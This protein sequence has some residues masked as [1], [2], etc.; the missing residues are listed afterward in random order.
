MTDTVS[1][2]NSEFADRGQGKGSTVTISCRICQATYAPS[3]E[4]HYLLQAPPM[5]LESAFMSMCHFCFRCR[6]PACPQCW[7]NVH[8]VCGECC[9]EAQLPFRAQTAPL[10]GVLFATTRQAQLHRKHA[11]PVRLICIRPGRF[12][13]M[14]S[15]DTAETM[16][17]Q[18]AIARNVLPPSTIQQQFEPQS[19]TGSHANQDIEHIPTRPPQSRQAM[20]TNTH[21]ADQPARQYRTAQ[22]PERS[23]TSRSIDE[24]ATRPPRSRRTVALNDSIQQPDREPTRHPDKS[25]GKR[26]EQII[27]GF[28][29]TLLFILLLTVVIALLSTEVNSHVQQLLH[30]DIRAEI[31]YLWQLI[32]QIHT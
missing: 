24:I 13:R 15:I 18:T 5:A 21:L 2:H 4:H 17:I 11:L 10:R 7:D 9:L 12:Q 3:Q 29:F 23:N 16:P 19:G 20:P 14:A 27:T 31:S 30:I 1:R 28:F 8:G 6:R 25:T 32:K 26:I 22:Q